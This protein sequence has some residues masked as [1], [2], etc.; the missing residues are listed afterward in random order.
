M[1]HLLKKHYHRQQVPPLHHAARIS[2]EFPHPLQVDKAILQTLR[3]HRQ[4]FNRLRAASTSFMTHTDSTATAVFLTIISSA[5]DSFLIVFV[6]RN[7]SFLEPETDLFPKKQGIEFKFFQRLAHTLESRFS[8]TGSTS[9]F[10][11]L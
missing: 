3:N 1:P 8:T 6:Y 5:R 4:F 2:G 11:S 10:L 7:T 9:P